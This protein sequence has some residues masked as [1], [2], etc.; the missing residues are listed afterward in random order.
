MCNCDAGIFA[1]EVL[2]SFSSKH[3]IQLGSPRANDRRSSLV[4]TAARRGGTH[5]HTRI[6]L[7]VLH[8]FRRF[9]KR[10]LQAHYRPKPTVVARG[11]RGAR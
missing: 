11:K 9:R 5:S 7:S 10:L 2:N 1:M 3:K 4:G 6:G 8:R